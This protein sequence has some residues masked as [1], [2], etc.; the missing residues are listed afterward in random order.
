VT[1]GRSLKKCVDRVAPG[2]P[3][4]NMSLVSSLGRAAHSEIRDEKE[5]R[6]RR[7]RRWD[8]IA[9]IYFVIVEAPV[10]RWALVKTFL[11]ATQD[12]QVKLN[13]ALTLAIFCFLA[14]VGSARPGTIDIQCRC[15]GAHAAS[16]RQIRPRGSR[17]PPSVLFNR[18]DLFTTPLEN[19]CSPRQT[20]TKTSAGNDISRFDLS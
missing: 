11:E 7:G 4:A 6:W 19:G 13:V 16:T 20:G 5:L 14:S 1:T 10:N 12:K 2:Q 3:P 17:L 9:K 8:S 15:H 18:T